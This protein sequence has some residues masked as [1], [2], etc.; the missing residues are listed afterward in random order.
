MQ[1]QRFK[2]LL[3]ISVKKLA[4]LNEFDKRRTDDNLAPTTA[5]NTG[6]QQWVRPD[7]YVIQLLTQERPGGGRS[8][9]SPI[10]LHT[11]NMIVT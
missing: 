10:L 6:S 5:L 2:R 3:A 11:V 1:E 9:D 7:T 4:K 8:P